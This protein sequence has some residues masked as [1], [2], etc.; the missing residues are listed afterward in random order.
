[1]FFFCLF[2]LPY[3]LLIMNTL[4]T[5]YHCPLSKSL[6]F[7]S[8]VFSLSARHSWISTHF[9]KTLQL[10]DWFTNNTKNKKQKKKNPNANTCKFICPGFEISVSTPIEWRWVKPSFCCPQYWKMTSLSRILLIL[11]CGNSCNCFLLKKC[12]LWFW[13]DLLLLSIKYNF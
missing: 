7:L 4:L 9:I 11:N 2:F 5:I 10:K 8:F 13:N 6:I 12:S 1:M 3:L